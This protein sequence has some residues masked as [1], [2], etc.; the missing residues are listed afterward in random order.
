M[1][2]GPAATAKGGPQTAP[3]QTGMTLAGLDPK[4]GLNQFCQRY[5]ARPVTKTDIVYTTTK[6]GLNQFQAIVKL[7]CLEGQEYAGE[8]SSSPKEAE[9]SAAQQALQAY[10]AIMS[11][12]PPAGA[13]PKK[14]KAAGV[15]GQEKAPRLEGAD[16]P[17]LTD[18]VKLN[19]LCM[20]IARRALVKGETAYETRGI[21]AGKVPEGFQTTVRMSCLPGDWAS[22]VFAGEVCLHKQAAEQS[23]AKIALAAIM[24]AEDLMTMANSKER[25]DKEPRARKAR[26][27]KGQPGEKGA[28]WG[29]GWRMP[30]GPDLP[31]EKVKEA[32]ILGEVL[33]WKGNFGWVKATEAIEHEAAALR[34]GKIYVHKQDLADGLEALT[35]GASVNFTVYVDPSGLGAEE[36]QLA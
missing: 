19:A 5:C 11:T 32:P 7:N 18:K 21:G 33:E 24:A 6:F 15:P 16:N 25:E 35:V 28:G 17:A 34:G 10:A 20:K 36:V 9:K 29:W 3:Q 26:A 2:P 31:R 1:I 12:L 22:K 23:A 13:G 4:T 30:T 14:K 8:L 27:G